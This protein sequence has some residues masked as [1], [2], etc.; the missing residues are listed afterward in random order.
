MQQVKTAIVTYNEE[1]MQFMDNHT[2]FGQHGRFS[3]IVILDS[4]YQFDIASSIV[5]SLIPMYFSSFYPIT[6][7]SYFI[8]AIEDEINFE[9]M[10]YELIE[11]TASILP[12]FR[13]LLD[14][15]GC[16]MAISLERLRIQYKVQ[17]SNSNPEK[18]GRAFVLPFFSRRRD[19]EEREVRR[20]V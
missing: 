19:S 12:T 14:P 13:S 4:H 11:A 17:Q 2:F 18:N 1:S 15:I 10:K 3:T 8:M 5:N 6:R 16:P 9:K 7:A 20:S